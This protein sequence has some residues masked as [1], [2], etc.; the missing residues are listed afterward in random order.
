M[1]VTDECCK[2]F[3]PSNRCSDT[4]YRSFQN[5]IYVDDELLFYSC[6]VAVYVGGGGGLDNLAPPQLPHG[7]FDEPFN[8]H[9]LLS[10]FAQLVIRR[11]HFRTF[12]NFKT[13][14]TYF[15]QGRGG[16]SLFVPNFT[17]PFKTAT[18]P[19]YRF[20]Q[21]NNKSILYTYDRSHR[22]PARSQTHT[23]TIAS[24]KKNHALQ[25]FFIHFQ[26]SYNLPIKDKGPGGYFL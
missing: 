20:R 21:V 24:S 26:T 17:L 8:S 3:A 18:D 23:N 4:L 10:L 25:F 1:Y 5:I 19:A 13:F 11:R 7:K 14:F 2:L 12:S 6:I 15:E 22:G 16:G 9:N